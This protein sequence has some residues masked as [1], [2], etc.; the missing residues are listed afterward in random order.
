MVTAMSV[1]GLGKGVGSDMD[2]DPPPSTLAVD[3]VF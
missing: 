1:W 2:L 3:T